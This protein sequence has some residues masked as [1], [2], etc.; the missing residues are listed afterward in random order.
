V[1]VTA[2]LI[3]SLR[4][5]AGDVFPLSSPLPHAIF[6]A[7]CLLGAIGEVSERERKEKREKEI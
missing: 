5:Y 3:L 7:T 1:I 6:A 4:Q 2:L